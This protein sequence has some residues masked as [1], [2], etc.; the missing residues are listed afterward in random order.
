MSKPPSKPPTIDLVRAAELFGIG[1]D[2]AYE[3]AKRGELCAGVPVLR[4]GGR[5]RVPTVAVER[6]LG[7]DLS[8]FLD[9]A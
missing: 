8:D 2:G 1:R 6:V 5:Y 9:A 4:V 7:I 3:A